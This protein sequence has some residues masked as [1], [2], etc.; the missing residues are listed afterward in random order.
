MILSLS[1][2]INVDQDNNTAMVSEMLKGTQESD[3]DI[4]AIN[5]GTVSGKFVNYPIT[6][7]AEGYDA[8]Q[9]PWYKKAIENKGE[10]VVTDPFVDA[11]TGNTIVAVSRTVEKDGQ[12]VGVIAIDVK[13]TTISEKI[14]T[15]QVGNTGYLFISDLQVMF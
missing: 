2:I 4:L 12:V 11:V 5:Y 1:G 9:R 6:K 8:T 7:M 13:L 15:K 3:S 10:T 14:A